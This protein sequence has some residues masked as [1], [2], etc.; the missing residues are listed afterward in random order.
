MVT[1]LDALEQCSFVPSAA[2]RRFRVSSAP[3]RTA[4]RAVAQKPEPTKPPPSEFTIELRFLGGLTDSQMQVFAEAAKRW[5]EVITG[6]LPAV[7]LPTGEVI[8]DVLIDAQGVFIDGVGGTLGRAGPQFIRD[9]FLPA[10]GIMQFDTA[11]L[12][13]MESDNSLLDVII[14]EMGHVLGI[15]TVWDDTNLLVGCQ[16][17]NPV[18]LGA[19]AKTEFGQLLNQGS[20]A[21][22]VAN[23][24]GRGTRCG[25]WREAVFGHE[26]MTGFLNAGP[27]PLSRLTIASLED[28][29]YEVNYDAANEYVLPSSHDLVMMGI[30]A[31]GHRQICQMC[32]G[33]VRPIDP[34]VLP[35]ASYV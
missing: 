16:T 15:G 18:F 22:P 2:G 3:P 35:E 12:E 28:L 9:S 6:D 8:D 21:V 25:H 33:G 26:L 29:G 23:T 17:A 32:G 30:G 31:D 34:I 5:S 7:R 14:H 27:N 4:E 1:Y 24:G 10:K 20:T 13:R 11:D 19:C